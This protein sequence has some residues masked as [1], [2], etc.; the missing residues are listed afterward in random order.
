MF[1][2]AQIVWQEQS[3]IAELEA[4]C[5]FQLSQYLSQR[6]LVEVGILP[7]L[8]ILVPLSATSALQSHTN[9]LYTI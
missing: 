7:L 9:D 4:D 5:L 3:D 2:N 8:A 6:S 1:C